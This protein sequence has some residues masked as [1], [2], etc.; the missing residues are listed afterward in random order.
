MLMVVGLA[1]LCGIVA[2]LVWGRLVGTGL[3]TALALIGAIVV[4]LVRNQKDL[5]ELEQG[6]VPEEVDRALGDAPPP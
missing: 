2:G 4:V 5:H 6:R 3:G 1:V